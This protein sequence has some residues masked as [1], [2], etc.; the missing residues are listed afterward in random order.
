MAQNKNGYGATEDTIEID[1]IALCMTLIKHL[2]IIILATIIT[3]IIGFGYAKLCLPVEYTAKTY[4]Y[5]SNTAD[6]SS[7]NISQSDINAS[8]SLVTTYI[9]I[10]QNNVVVKAVA[11]QLS[12][13]YDATVLA[14]CFTLENGTPSVSE[15]S[16]CVSMASSNDTELF[17]ISA[18][19]KDPEISAAICDIYADVAP[20]FLMR[21]V[22][23]GSVEVIGA[24][25]IPTSPSS[26]NVKKYTL[27]GVAIGFCLMVLLYV[28]LF[29]LDR[30]VK[31]EDDIR[32]LG[33]SYFGDIP[34]V[35][36]T[37]KKQVIPDDETA[38][39][40][41]NSDTPFA[42]SESYRAVRTN[43]M[44]S[45]GLR[46]TKIVA[47]TSSRSGEGKSTTA[48]NL[49]I[50]LAMME[51][52]ILLIDADM[53]VP[54]Q[55]TRLGVA[56]E[57]GLSNV[58]VGMNAFKEVVRTGILKQLDLLSAGAIPPNPSELLASQAMGNFLQKVEDEYEYDYIIIDTPPVGVV[59]DVLGLSPYIGGILFVTR[60]GVVTKEEVKASLQSIELVSA[61]VLGCVL[62][63]TETENGGYYAGKHGKYGKYNR[64]DGYGKYNVDHSA[65][66]T[67]VL[68]Q[69]GEQKPDK[70]HTEQKNTGSEKTKKKK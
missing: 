16:S 56:N 51:K 14:E 3:G 58:L 61:S 32:S 5:V 55:H 17:V 6:S 62:N 38:V 19:T 50:A 52:R 37:K 1:L 33:V 30:T 39:L 11:L 64:Y 25:E 68:V 59:S 43:L 63:M 42:L 29:L 28:I 22:G 49:A 46:D 21:I 57:A 66:Q 27:V 12:E 53:R 60:Q 48:V 67:L 31:T 13:K 23:A 7:S 40:I 18:E 69:D 70:N 2:P 34:D 47:V 4:M 54:V 44:F 9:E 26:P 15:L 41:T 24:A 35:S 10:L 20:D 36:T 8:Q 65:E 45:L